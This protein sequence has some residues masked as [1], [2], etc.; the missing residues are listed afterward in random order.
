MRIVRC[1]NFATGFT[2]SSQSIGW[3]CNG[4]VGNTRLSPAISWDSIPGNTRSFVFIHF[5]MDCRILFAEQLHLGNQVVFHVVL[6]ET[7]KIISQIVNNPKPRDRTRAHIC[8]N[9]IS[10]GC[11]KQ[12]GFQFFLSQNNSLWRAITS[13]FNSESEFD[14]KLSHIFLD[15][16]SRSLTCKRPVD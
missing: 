6:F 15:N 4:S 3:N 9:T 8:T 11:F 13:T 12:F 5:G 1:Q 7:F 10:G 14:V 2:S 16:E